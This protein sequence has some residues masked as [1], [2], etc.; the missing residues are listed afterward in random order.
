MEFGSVKCV[1]SYLAVESQT[2]QVNSIH[3]VVKKYK[4][5]YGMIMII[6]PK[7][8]PL[9]SVRILRMKR[10]VLDLI[11]QKYCPIELEM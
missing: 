5:N 11:K 9:I 3:S 10:L 1:K 8:N 4:S 6:G 7:L 2:G